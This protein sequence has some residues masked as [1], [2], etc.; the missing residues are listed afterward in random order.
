M[1][2]IIF[3]FE[4]FSSNSIALKTPESL[5][6]NSFDFC[7]IKS[8][9]FSITVSNTFFSSRILFNNCVFCSTRVVI[10]ATFL[11]A[12]NFSSFTIF[13]ISLSVEI[14]ASS[15]DFRT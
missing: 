1:A 10:V 3:L 13:S 6:C 2:E 8:Y 15:S 5:P 7:S 9:L 14:L 11:T 12:D 4:V